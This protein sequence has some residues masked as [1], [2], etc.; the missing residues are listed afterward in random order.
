MRLYTLKIYHIQVLDPAPYAVN[1]ENS[2]L[3]IHRYLFLQLGKELYHKKVTLYGEKNTVNTV[4]KIFRHIGV[5]FSNI[6]SRE[7][8]SED[9]TIYD[10]FYQGSDTS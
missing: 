9:G 6:I 8:I 2:D 4:K 5:T 7:S 10:I 3:R 1:F